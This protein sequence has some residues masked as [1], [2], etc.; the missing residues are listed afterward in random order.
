MIISHKYK[1]IFLKTNKTAGTSIEIALSK[2]CGPDDVITPIS[3]VDEKLRKELGFRGPQNN[4]LSLIWNYSFRDFKILFRR[5]KC[6]LRFFNHMSAREVRKEVGAQIWDEYYK[7][8]FERN[9]WDRLISLYYWWYKSKQHPPPISEF[10]ESEKP[11]ILKKRG[12][13]LYTIN[14]LIAVDRVCLFENKEEELEAI[15]NRLHLPEKIEL[16]YTKSQHR[17]DKRSYRDILN[18]K[19][20]AKVAELFHDEIALFGYKF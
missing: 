6:K 18:E 17:K 5:R 9:P 16:L 14:G 8:C 19:D 13:D 7:F 11:L 1:F 10:I 2:Y 20:R 15:K 12:Y 3:S 4:S